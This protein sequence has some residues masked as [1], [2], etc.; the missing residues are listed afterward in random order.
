MRTFGPGIMFASTAIGISHLIQSTRAGAEFGFELVIFVILANV[1]KYPF[2]EFSSRYANVTGTSLIDGYKKLG[3]WALGL[4]FMVTIASMF[5]VTA[6]VGLVTAGFMEN[7]FGIT[8]F[9]VWGVALLF[10][11]CSIILIVGRYTVLDSLIK[12]IAAVILI[13]TVLAFI[14]A[15][16]NGPAEYIDGF[17]EPIIWS[18]T[19]LFFVIALMGWM[20]IPIDA[21]AWHGLWTLERIRQTNFKPALKE[22]LLDFNFGYVIVASLSILFL[23]LGA[24]IFYGTGTELPESSG[25]FAHKVV[26]I[27]TETIG[28]WSE[29]IISVSAFSVMFGTIIAVFDGYSRSI[30]RTGQLLT[31]K[32]KP[33]S[34]STWKKYVS[35]I[36]ILAVISF[37]VLLQFGNKIKELVDFATT[38]SFVLSP[39][40]AYFNIRLVSSKYIDIAMMPP[41]WLRVLSYVGLIFLSGFA[42]VFIII[43]I[44]TLL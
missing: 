26:Q 9:G 19:T 10:A 6:A 33:D 17:K 37:T 27:Y 40:I 36:L 28:D 3:K 15:I 39:V 12:I 18:G 21:S 43:Y 14:F 30:L 1:L 20:P 42:I 25:L 11:I 41:T 35:V 5:F 23:I 7:L 4:Y 2:F 8:S 16:Y 13:S 22:T 34:K 32:S 44:P 38:I 29:L 24:Y 31:S